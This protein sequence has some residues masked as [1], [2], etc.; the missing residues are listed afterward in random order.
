MRW[1]LPFLSLLLL[2]NSALLAAN[3]TTT[4]TD[5][6]V[7]TGTRTERALKDVP[8]RTEVITAAD[9]NRLHARDLNEALQYVPGLQLRP[10]H[11]KTGYGAWMQGIDANRVLI[12]VDG[13]PVSAST[14]S[15]VDTT[16]IAVTDIER[17]EIIKGAV[18][19]LY[20]TSA[21]DGVINIITRQPTQPFS[22]SATLSGGSWGDQNAED[23]PL[24]Q[25]HI[26]G[27]AAINQDRWSLSL[28]GDLR[29]QDG[30]KANPD[31][32]STQGYEGSK[33][34]LAAQ[35]QYRFT[36]DLRLTLSPR[37]YQESLLNQ[38]TE[39][40][41]GFGSLPVEKKENTTT[42]HLG[43]RL[44][45][46]SNTG[47]GW[48]LSGMTE[49]FTG[50]TQQDKPATSQVD[51]QRNTDMTH[52]LLAFQANY[53]F[54]RHQ[55]TFGGQLSE[56]SMDVIQY[57]RTATSTERLVEVDQETAS[58]REV[59]A[60]HS[61][62]IGHHLELLPGFRLHYDRDAGT[63]LSPM[64]NSLFYH[65]LDRGDR[66]NIRLGAGNGYRV[67]NLKERFYIFD[68]SHLGY[69]VM[70]NSDLQ[71]ESSISTQ[72]GIEWLQPSGARLEFS[73]FHNLITD[74]IESDLD[75]DESAAQNLQIYRYQNFEKAR[76]QG[77][78]L[79]IFTPLTPTLRFDLGYT[80]MQAEDRLTGL[81][82]PNRPEHQLKVGLSWD[83]PIDGLELTVKARHESRQFTDSINTHETPA[84][85]VWDLKSNYTLNPHWLFFGG[86]NNLT[87]IQKNFE[88][89][90]NRPEEGRFIYLGLRW[91]H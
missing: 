57:K 8:V 45:Q 74:L 23:F 14:G 91:Q 53:P 29:N 82:L 9:I 63:H 33:S 3:H 70:G 64:I 32:I 87:N 48:S 46:R 12:L 6:L 13:N 76:T 58:T 43:A 44:E 20:G 69:K 26:K 79:V 72:A 83:S 85:T 73:L 35:W 75:P 16:Q 39:F 50:E 17:I 65:T 81:D 40:V 49:T 36:P 55:L 27:Q 89:A 80:W 24:A 60:Q 62:F 86:V 30:W 19:A 21:M 47:L 7:V 90:D 88:Q 18:S 38:M 4:Q 22:A 1:Q 52:H 41:P 15:A 2:S 5:T 51:Q 84:F 25:R 37:I 77:A 31:S 68:H 71:P 61:W 28:N 11:G 54:D 42:L 10:I 34:N 56:E 66:I 59:F 78:E 67:A